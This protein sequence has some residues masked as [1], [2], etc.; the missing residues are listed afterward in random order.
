[1]RILQVSHGFPPKENAGVEHYTYYLSRALAHLNH[2]VSLFCRGEDPEKE[3]FSSYEE[4][5]DGLRVRR[6]INRLTRIDN[7]RTLYDNPFMDSLFLQTLEQEKPDVVHFQHIFG[8]SGH[9]VR[10]A[11]GKGYPVLFTLH[12]FFT[13]CNRIQLLKRD[14]R[15]CDG[16]LYGLECVSCI[17]TLSPQDI[18]TRMFMRLKDVLPFPVIKWT[19]RFL[20]P[21]RY[22][23]QRGYEAFHRYRYMYEVFKACD[24]LLT[25]SHYV[26]NFFVRYYRSMASKTKVL[27]LGVPPFGE[28]PYPKERNGKVR[29][30]Y[31]GT[32]L[33]H[34]GLH[35]LI[36]AFKA[37]P[38][39]RAALTIYGSRT[40]WNQDYYDQLREQATGFEVHFRGPYQREELPDRSKEQDVAVFPAIWPETFSIVIREA[41][42]LGLPV[43]A[44]RIGAIPEAIT[45]GVNGF[46]FTPRDVE[47]LRTTMLRLLDAP[48]LIEEMALRMP[49]PKSMNEHALEILQLYENLT[50]GGKR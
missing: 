23:G 5:V 16:P 26:R 36:D 42:L 30:C 49:K 33:P 38:K 22:L 28:P 39:G 17:E 27:P 13:L 19:K 7:H 10:L 3:E 15:L 50:T 9:L 35:I 24:L 12:D 21:P 43:I 18:R 20:I 2:D 34:K 14:G 29:F 31:F 8:L 41:S 6:A 4:V 44:S 48:I 25:P 45:E 47:G 40:P 11:K 46:L 37:L 32:L 1:M